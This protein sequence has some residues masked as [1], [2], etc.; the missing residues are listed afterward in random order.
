METQ[1]VTIG[2][3]LAMAAV[4]TVLGMGLFTMLS[5]KDISGQQSNKLMWRR[6]F[7]QGVALAIFAVL[8]I[9]KK[10]HG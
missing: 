3:F 10:K 9:L 8:L 5:G 6:V 7:F 2:L 1:I 4:V